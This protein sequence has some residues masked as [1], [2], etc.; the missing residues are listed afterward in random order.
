MSNTYRL[1]D[2][3]AGRPGVGSS[4]TQPP[5]ASAAATGGWLLGRIFSVTGQ[6][7]WLGGYWFWCPPG[8]D[9]VTHKF[10]LWNRFGSAG[11]DEVVVP[12]SVTSGAVI[13]GQMN[14]V[15]L[16]TPIPLAPGTLYVAA[17]GYTA[18]VGIPLSGAQF[19]SGEPYAAGVV[20]GILTGWSDL[21]GANLFPAAA[22]NYNMGQGVF[23]NS[24]GAD[25]SVAMPNAGGTGDNFWV[26]VSVTDT[27]PAGYSGSYRM[28]PN[29]A[30]LGNFSLDTA[31]AF[32]LGVTASL[33]SRCQ[34]NRWWFY[35]P[36][37]V[38]RLPDQCAVFRTSDQS[39]VAVQPAAAW[40]GAAAA[41]W[42]SA[43]PAAPFALPA[44]QYKVCIF[45]S[46]NEIWNAAVP[47]YYSTGFAAAGLTSG[48]ISIPN[49]AGAPPPG[50]MSYHPSAVLTYPDTNV[51]P[52]FYGVDFEVTP[53]A[54]TGTASVAEGAPHTINPGGNTLMQGS[55]TIGAEPWGN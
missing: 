44:G 27:A 16:A 35:S 48:P 46:T 26:D 7:G 24:L 11:G 43:V 36:A 18:A 13:A 30:D 4:G 25:P 6:V 40:S 47:A 21:G 38:T 9:T 37:G 39:L 50:Q 15:A 12:G 42:I 23:S 19:G 49:N 14:F 32:T 53:A 34:F 1:D 41:G 22:Q 31:N 3:Q 33:A 28:Y 55:M 54:A 8:G 51:G 29:M 5:A 20:N 10:A 45:N 2:G 17:V 52:F